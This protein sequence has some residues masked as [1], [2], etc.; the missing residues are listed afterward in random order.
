MTT[1][2][3]LLDT[4]D[5]ASDRRHLRA[6]AAQIAA[7]V[8]AGTTHDEAAVLR[9]AEWILDEHDAAVTAAEAPEGLTPGGVVDAIV[10]AATAR[11]VAVSS[12][13]M[14]SLHPIHA[15]KD[16]RATVYCWP[17]PAANQARELLD[18]LGAI[19]IDVKIGDQFGMIS[20]WSHDLGAT[21]RVSIEAPAPEPA[22]VEPE[23]PAWP[24]S[25]ERLEAMVAEVAAVGE[26][27][28][29][30]A[31]REQAEATGGEA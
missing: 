5:D 14:E 8:L 16:R 24:L 11:D 25:P 26:W 28:D 17:Y 23:A 1:F 22:P 20:G 4:S 19:D 10:E 9:V 3:E 27:Q 6:A 13:D 21:V 31:A 29:E 30:L 15:A 2:Y 18:D 7:G 12:V